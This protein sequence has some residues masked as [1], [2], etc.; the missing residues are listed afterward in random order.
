[1]IVFIVITIIIFVFTAI[2]GPLL[3][4]TVII[5]D[6]IITILCLDKLREKTVKITF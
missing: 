4:F 5:T 2:T 3:L 1:M 6:I